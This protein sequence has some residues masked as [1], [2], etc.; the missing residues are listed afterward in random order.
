MTLAIE[1]SNPTSTIPR[2][3]GVSLVA[4]VKCARLTLNGAS[5]GWHCY[6]SS[7]CLWEDGDETFA[8]FSH[9][10]SWRWRK[11]FHYMQ[12]YYYLLATTNQRRNMPL[13]FSAWESFGFFQK[14]HLEQQSTP[15]T[16]STYIRSRSNR[17]KPMSFPQDQR[18]IACMLAFFV[19]VRV[20]LYCKYHSF[21]L[22]REPVTHLVRIE[23]NW[24]ELNC[25]KASCSP[26]L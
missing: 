4:N 20:V 6:R 25:T 12:Y 14:Q 8:F 23:L 11:R 26:P 2:R 18:C 7:D 10:G 3:S 9:F 19:C 13:S 16:V 17:S 22:F 1:I 24:I 5:T 21:F 15:C